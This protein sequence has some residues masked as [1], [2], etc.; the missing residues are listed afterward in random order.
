MSRRRAS[1]HRPAAAEQ[2]ALRAEQAPAA[3]ANETTRRG[4]LGRLAVVLGVLAG[5]E[6]A[7][8]V[9]SFFKPRGSRPEAASRLVTAGAVS[10][11]APGSV[12]AFPEGRFYLVRLPEDG[13]LAVHATCTHLGCTVPWD[14]ATGR[15]VCPCHASAFDIRGEVLGPPAPRPLD[16]FPVRIENDLV[17]VDVTSPQRR[18]RFEPSQVVSG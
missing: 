17:R 14:E 5:A 15:F 7:W 11:F 13:F 8:I 3:G 2:E 6:L 12:T 16:L 1:P 18:S 9:G 4:L 10:D